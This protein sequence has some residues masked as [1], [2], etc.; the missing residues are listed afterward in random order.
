M[1]EFT[2]GTRPA[3]P[4]FAAITTGE[5]LAYREAENR[6]RASGAAR[7]FL[8]EPDPGAAIGWQEIALRNNFV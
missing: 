5:L 3:E 6:F 7:A 1:S 4:D 8:G 2:A